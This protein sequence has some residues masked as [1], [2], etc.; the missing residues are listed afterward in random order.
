MKQLNNNLMCAL[1]IRTT[2]PDPDVDEIYELGIIALNEDLKPKEGV[3]PIDFRMKINEIERMKRHNKIA[4]KAA[5][6]G[7]TPNQAAL[8]FMRWLEKFALPYGKGIIP[9]VYNWPRQQDFLIRWLGQETF[10]S[11][12]NLE[13][14]DIL[15]IT[16]FLNDRSDIR[17]LPRFPFPKRDF[18]SIAA[19]VGV[20]MDANGGAL[21]WALKISEVYRSM[22]YSRGIMP[23]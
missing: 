3:M 8:V 13:Y 16:M 10:D 5:V 12:F 2:G 15:C 1:H 6:D 11:M 14:R 17:M 22:L 19:Y 7:L 21:H 20:E 4:V 9:L 23:L 18:P